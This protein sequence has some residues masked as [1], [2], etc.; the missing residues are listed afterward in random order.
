MARAAPGTYYARSW[1]RLAGRFRGSRVVVDV[2]LPPV[3]LL[4][5]SVRDVHVFDLG[6]V[7]LVGVRGEQVHPV[8]T[9]MQVVG[10]V[11]MLVTVLRSLV[12]VTTLRLR[13]HQAYL[14]SVAYSTDRTL[15]G[16]EAQT[17]LGFSPSVTPRYVAL[18]TRTSRTMTD[19]EPGDEER[20]PREADEMLA[21]IREVGTRKDRP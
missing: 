3:L 12:V 18:K 4:P 2:R 17:A 19:H 15:P 21:E 14:H 13:L 20:H 9:T 16:E 5:V 8:L 6:V 7:V 1:G 10:H 11:E